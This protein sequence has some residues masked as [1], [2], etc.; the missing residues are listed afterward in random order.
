MQDHL[1]EW[2]IVIHSFTLNFVVLLCSVYADATSGW[3]KALFLNVQYLPGLAEAE[4]CILHRRWQRTQHRSWAGHRR[5]QGER[6]G[7]QSHT[8]SDRLCGSDTYAPGS[9]LS[10]SQR[11]AEPEFQ[12][13]LYKTRNH[14]LYTFTV[15]LHKASVKIS[16][17]KQFKNSLFDVSHINHSQ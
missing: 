5:W 6:A 8:G 12:L 10:T 4:P 1:A 14:L 9:Y 2:G 11:L 17:V 3:H 15:H 7:W 16:S 13:Y